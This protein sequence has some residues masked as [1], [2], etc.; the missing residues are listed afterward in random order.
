MTEASRSRPTRKDRQLSLLAPV[1]SGLFTVSWVVLGSV[2]P[3]YQVFDM[4]IDDYSP[5]SQPIS[6]LGLGVTAPWMNATFVICGAMITVGLAAATRTWPTAWM[7]R[8]RLAARVLVV[9]S[10]I[11]IG[12]CGLFTLEA[13]LPHLVGFLLAVGAPGLGYIAGGLV[14][15]RADPWL[16]RLLLV[17]GPL[18]MLLLVTFMATFDPMSAA[19]NRGV[20]GLTQRALVTVSLIA[21]AAIGYRAWTSPRAVA[22]RPDDTALTLRPRTG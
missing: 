8:T 13:V 5:V 9:V 11:G 2:S 21:T 12:M 1:G 10:G 19:E 22:R 6:G 15:R 14:L 20:A 18:T 3:G 16:S 4:R 17:A 7:S